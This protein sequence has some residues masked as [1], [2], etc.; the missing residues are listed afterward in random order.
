MISSKVMSACK[1]VPT[2]D[3]PSLFRA[4]RE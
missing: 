3:W 2:S 1:G 4:A